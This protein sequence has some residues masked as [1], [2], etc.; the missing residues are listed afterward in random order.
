M[1]KLM[2]I[3]LAFSLIASI[4]V[5]PPSTQ[6]E[7]QSMA[8]PV[9][10]CHIY[11]PIISNGPN[12]L[13]LCLVTDTNGITE[14]SFNEPAW[15]GMLDAKRD[16]GASAVYRE[17]QMV[18]DYQTNIESFVS[19]GCD[20][21]V[22]VGFFQADAVYAAAQNHPNQ[23]FSIVDFTYDPILSNV[24]SQSFLVDQPAFLSGYLAAGMTKTGKVGTF[25]G[26]PIPTVTA[27][28]D[29]F[30]RG[31]NYYN[32]HKGTSVIVYG[33]DINNPD[34]GLYSMSFDDQNKGMELGNSLMDEGADIILPVAGSVGLGT[35]AAVKARGNAFVI[36]VD[37]DWAL[38][39]PDYAGI[40]LTS[41][42]KSPRG[43][44]YGVIQKLYNGE[45]AGGTFFGTLANQGVRL[46]TIHSS[47]PSQ[48]LTEVEQ[49]KAGIIAGTIVTRPN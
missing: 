31:V 26:F 10:G 32:Q 2:F 46:G 49:I 38:T 43:T 22:S 20:L 1:R 25:G 9:D 6:V 4:L 3:L 17:S 21:I 47:V 8:C 41:V 36:G 14:P 42:M 16:F 30:A 24:V 18:A 5:F 27:F 35:A 19:E 33:W 12:P 23:K 45:F 40:I 34:N 7:A 13:K 29:G 44:T 39:N 15:Q 28:M 48:L 37:S 11:I